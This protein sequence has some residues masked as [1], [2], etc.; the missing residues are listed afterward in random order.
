M[1]SFS[2]APLRDI[3]FLSAPQPELQR[4]Y[5]GAFYRKEWLQR[6]VSSCEH[7]SRSRIRHIIR[8]VSLSGEKQIKQ[9]IMAFH[10]YLL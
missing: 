7:Y 1:Y 3:F 2:V 10:K 6:N 8:E 4:K 5:Y 9:A